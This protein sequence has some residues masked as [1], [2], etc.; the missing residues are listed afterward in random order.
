MKKKNFK[1]LFLSLLTLPP[2]TAMSGHGELSEIAIDA[3][4]LMPRTLVEMADS[5]LQGDTLKKDKRPLF[6]IRVLPRAKGDS[7]LLRWAPSEFAPWAFSNQWGYNLYRMDHKGNIDTLATALRPM[8]L[9]KMRQNFASND[10]LA[11]AA[12]Q[13]L[14]RQGTALD[15]VAA[16]G[17]DGLIGVYEEQQTRYAY[18]MLLAELR[19]DIAE[20]MA[21]R[22]VDRN[23]K[24]GETYKYVVGSAVPDSF[25]RIATVPVM[26][27]NVPYKAPRYNPTITDSLGLN[28]IVLYWPNSRLYS[29]HDIERRHNGGE[30]V[31]LNNKPFITLSANEAAAPQYNMFEDKGMQVGT[32]EYRLRGYDTFGDASNYSE[33]HKIVMPDLLA[34]TPPLMKQFRVDRSNP[35]ALFAE[36]I[37]KKTQMEDD[38]AGYNVFYYNNELSKEIGRAHV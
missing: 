34:P 19:P 20:A 26:V 17:S 29:T 32:Y 5:S 23:V 21:L 22:F 4:T 13:L 18:A 2:L 7:V 6:M 16:T 28:G 38:F 25:L 14:Y 3:S 35:D 27:K 1:I 24:K 11:G 8:P 36:I 37:W 9:D 15:S 12:A 31:K 10:S 30:W 33:I